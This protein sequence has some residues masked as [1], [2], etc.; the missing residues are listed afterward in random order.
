MKWAN[1]VPLKS[2]VQF[3]LVD[4]GHDSGLGDQALNVILVEIADSDRLDPALVAKTDQ[5]LLCLDILVFHRLGP[6]D[7][8][9][10]KIIKVEPC[11]RT[12]ECAQGLVV[13]MIEDPEFCRDK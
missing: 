3:D 5:G 12:V 10:I 8:I 7:Q 1:G 6:M 9:K 11:D 2:R 13:A 4:R